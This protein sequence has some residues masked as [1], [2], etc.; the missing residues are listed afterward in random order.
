MPLTDDNNAR[1]LTLVFYGDTTVNDCDPN[2]KKRAISIRLMT[3][4]EKKRFWAIKGTWEHSKDRRKPTREN[5]DN[6]STQKSCS[7]PR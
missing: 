6:V 1:N 3:S 2:D 7:I 4:R 5:E